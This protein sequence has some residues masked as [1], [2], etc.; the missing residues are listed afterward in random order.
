[1]RIRLLA[2]QIGDNMKFVIIISLIFI[3]L[4]SFSQG[5]DLTSEYIKNISKLKGEPK[6]QAIIDLGKLSDP[7]SINQLSAY[8]KDP[9]DSSIRVAAVTATQ[10]VRTYNAYLVTLDALNDPTD[11][12][13]IAALQSLNIITNELHGW[14]YPGNEATES[15]VKLYNSSKNDTIKEAAFLYLVTKNNHQVNNIIINAID[16]KNQKIRIISL[17]SPLLQR[18]T[19]KMMTLISDSN[20]DIK[21][22]LA[23]IAGNM[24]SPQG[25]DILKEL[26]QDK[27]PQVKTAAIQSLINYKNEDAKKIVL[28]LQDNNDVVISSQAILTAA[29]AGYADYAKLQD[30]F[31]HEKQLI[32]KMAIINAMRYADDETASRFLLNELIS[33][34]TVFS[35]NFSSA[36]QI[37]T[38]ILIAK[39]KNI[40]S[41]YT[42][43]YFEKPP[44]TKLNPEILNPEVTPLYNSKEIEIRV[45]VAILL[46]NFNNSNSITTLQK[47]SKD[48]DISVRISAIN[49]LV[50][51]NTSES[52]SLLF[53]LLTDRVPAVK[54]A[55]IRGLAKCRYKLANEKLIQLIKDDNTP[56]AIEAVTAL[57]VINAKTTSITGDLLNSYKKAPMPVQ[58]AII[59]ALGNTEDT[60]ISPYL[61]EF[62]L[63]AP[64]EIMMAVIIASGKIHD[65]WI[66]S[67]IADIMN[68]SYQYDIGMKIAAAEA[69]SNF[70]GK[71]SLQLLN[72]FI[73]NT[74]PVVRNAAIWSLSKK[75]NND[76]KS[77]LASLI[78]N[79]KTDYADR[80]TAI[81][82]L[83]ADKD[84]KAIKICKDIMKYEI[85]PQVKLSA[86]TS[87]VNNKETTIQIINDWANTTNNSELLY[88]LNELKNKVN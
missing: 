51:I 63:D 61:H 71:E 82:S 33:A 15:V 16:D 12:V 55:V 65:E 24:K 6:A 34:K 43:Y 69:L 74:I 41:K 2:K 14:I 18:N 5:I 50:L 45:A 84:E 54:I 21:A 78:L 23:N 77:I 4:L 88:I 31:N 70:E 76:A 49:S 30:R 86:L 52:K 39:C 1:M 67:K 57:G 66:I 27:N 3:P 59:Y 8:A 40:P 64:R 53:S 26:V 7:R 38:G 75:D 56:I 25:F 68:A 29:V 13:K 9:T 85:N 58:S 11:D 10:W 48:D 28:Q 87:L 42:D 80:A 46:G 20:N 44:T 81:A 36:V 73:Y 32:I 72:Y 62:I 79:T 60:R 83:N 37:I 47:L 35:E 17:S 22:S 19:A